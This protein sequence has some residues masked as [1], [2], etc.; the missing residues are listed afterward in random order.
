MLAHKLWLSKPSTVRFSVAAF[1][2]FDKNNEDLLDK[3]LAE[4]EKALFQEKLST[5][6]QNYKAIERL[7]NLALQKN[8]INDEKNWWHKLLTLSDHELRLLPLGFIKKYGS[9]LTFLR[10]MER[11]L[12][13]KES[14]NIEDFYK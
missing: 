13:T 12:A 14:R 1:S 2:K 7:S 3:D 10:K 11:E 4:R 8:F 5:K 6:E 9:M